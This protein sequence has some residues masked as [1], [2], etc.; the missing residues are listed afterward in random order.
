M[1]RRMPQ[2]LAPLT[3]TCCIVATVGLTAGCNGKPAAVDPSTPKPG[4]IAIRSNEGPNEHAS[5]TWRYVLEIR[6]KGTK[7]ETRVGLLFKEDKPVVA[8]KMGESITTPWGPMRWFGPP[9]HPIRIRLPYEFGWLA[10]G[11]YDRPLD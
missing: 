4:F 8:A 5:G 7:S 2:H 10:R 1:E 11:T 9:P 3:L 6:A